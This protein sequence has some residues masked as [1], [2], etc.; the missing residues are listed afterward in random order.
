MSSF[1]DASTRNQ[2]TK[3]EFAQAAFARADFVKLLQMKPSPTWSIDSKESTPEIRPDIVDETT[4]WRNACE[5]SRQRLLDIGITAAQVEAVRFTHN[6]PNY[7]K[8]ESNLYDSEFWRVQQI[9]QSKIEQKKRPVPSSSADAPISSR[10]RRKTREA[11]VTKSLGNA[12]SSRRRVKPP[13]S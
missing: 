2:H 9:R 1:L 12:R 4:H 5:F 7:W 13:D 11:K 10:L 8:A 6:D 3:A